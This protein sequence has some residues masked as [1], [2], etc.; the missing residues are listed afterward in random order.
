[1]YFWGMKKLNLIILTLV[2]ALA[3]ESCYKKP[4]ASFTTSKSEYIAGDTVH[5]KNTSSNGHS[6][7]WALP[8]GRKLTTTNVDY[9]IPTNQGFAQLT[10]ILNAYSRRE[11]KSSSVTKT[12]DVIPSSMF[13]V[14]N[15]YNI[16]YPLNVSSQPF[17]NNWRIDAEYLTTNPMV[18]NN[19]Y[20]TIILP[21]TS[22]P[23]SNTTYTLQS[24]DT[25]APG[26]AYVNIFQVTEA[27]VNYTSQSGQLDITITNGKVHAVFNHV[28]TT[29][30][31]KI[32]GDITVP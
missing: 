15:T 27:N 7:L 1:M 6:F 22:P 30:G 2:I 12:V 14:D 16:Y 32:S 26:Y 9:L 18:P 13:G 10:F 21:G 17:G 8:D 20:L 11:K 19:A 31:Y 28:S 29:F 25:L 3:I 24:N 5:L 4:E 23:T